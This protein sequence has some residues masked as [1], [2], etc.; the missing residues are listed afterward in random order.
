M[1]D[2]EQRVRED[3]REAIEVRECEGG[4][5][6]PHE[7]CCSLCALIDDHVPWLL[8]ELE[9]RTLTEEEARRVAAVE[10]DMDRFADVC[11]TAAISLVGANV[12]LT[13]FLLATIKRLTGKGEG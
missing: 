9:R 8:S 13:L 6:G 2:Q 3:L 11:E 4:H 10:R 1:N 5:G 12:D 7:A